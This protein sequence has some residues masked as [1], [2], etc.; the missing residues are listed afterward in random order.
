MKSASERCKVTEGTQWGRTQ[1]AGMKSDS[2]TLHYGTV[3]ILS[4]DRWQ[5]DATASVLKKTG[6]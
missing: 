2:L 1:C 5:T 3:P 6:K 4:K